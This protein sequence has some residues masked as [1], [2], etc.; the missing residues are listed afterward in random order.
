[1]ML[2]KVISILKQSEADAWEVVSTKTRGWEFYFIKKRLDQNRAK[3]IE[4][5]R[6]KI[7]K[8]S[9]NGESMGSAVAA[10]PPT[11]S[12]DELFSLVNKLV[13]EA[14]LIKNKSFD[15]VRPSET[16]A[17]T[18][19]FHS[20][21]VMSDEYFRAMNAVEESD[22][23]DLNSYELFCSHVTKRIVNS[24]G[25]DVSMTYPVSAAEVVINARNQ[26]REIELYRMYQSGSCDPQTLTADIQ[27]TMKLGKDRLTAKPT[28]EIDGSIPVVFSTEASR[29][30][31][32]Y[33]LGNLN[34]AYVYRKLSSFVIGEP[35]SESSDGDRVTLRSVRFLPN[36]SGNG[37]FDE[38]GSLIRDKMLLDAGIPVAY[39][40]SR[41][42][43]Q[44][45]GLDDSFMVRN[46]VVDGGHHT[47]SEI[48]S[49]DYLELV[50]FSDFQVDDIAGDIFGEIRLGYLHRNGEILAVTGG[51]VSG[52]MKDNLVDLWMS[53]T[54]V[55]Y[56]NVILPKLTRLN[57]VTVT[58]VRANND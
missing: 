56:N 3:D 51:S 22:T 15:L 53:D 43:S 18:P 49:G 9:D 7:Y 10:V 11:A 14:S 32:G 16:A 25:V 5:I 46:W 19:R 36:S 12:E 39:W 27:R 6:V 17:D 30:I 31:Y 21:P 35:I 29:E 47:E 38:E 2:N 28:P 37:G 4:E 50:E 48:R 26:D 33:F 58:G 20:L 54:Q 42:F 1:M 34:A 44:Y 52:D 24:N 13:Y 45:L 41:M 23:E 57:H 40:G 55:Q 8:K